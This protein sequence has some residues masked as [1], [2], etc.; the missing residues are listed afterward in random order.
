M[1]LSEKMT[2][3]AGRIRGHYLGTTH[4]SELLL[5]YAS[6]VAQLEARLASA[7]AIMEKFVHKVDTGRA[8]S[9]ETYAEM[10][11]WMEDE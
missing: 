5:E 4:A 2:A 9:K 11:Q 3:K 6:E 10:K 1:K 7:R 8:R